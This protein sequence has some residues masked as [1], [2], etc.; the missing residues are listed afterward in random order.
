M[1]IIEETISYIQQLHAR[2]ASRMLDRDTR[3][4]LD[5]I[6]E[7]E[8]GAQQLEEEEEGPRTFTARLAELCSN[9]NRPAAPVD[10]TSEAAV[11]SEPSIGTTDQSEASIETADRLCDSR[12]DCDGSDGTRGL[13][14]QSGDKAEGSEDVDSERVAAAI[15]LIQSS[16]VSLVNGSDKE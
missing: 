15:G 10:S 9:N 7:A 16:F 14:T 2:L 1:D 3:L 13:Q 11:Q 4:T 12:P 5:H 8:R 6:Q